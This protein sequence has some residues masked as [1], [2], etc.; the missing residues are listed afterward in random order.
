MT[1]LNCA[2]LMRALL[3]LSLRVEILTIGN[4]RLFLKKLESLDDCFPRFESIVSSLRSCVSL[5]YS[6]SEHAKQPLYALD[7]SV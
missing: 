6:D 1:S 5:A 7:D 4:I 3:R 2:I